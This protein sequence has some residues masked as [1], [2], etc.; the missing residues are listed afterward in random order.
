M[1]SPLN[2]SVAIAPKALFQK[3]PGFLIRPFNLFVI[4]MMGG[5]W[6]TTLFREAKKGE[7]PENF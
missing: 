3:K 7:K 4:S 5:M 2:F 1:F 6:L